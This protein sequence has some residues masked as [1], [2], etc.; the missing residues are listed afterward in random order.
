[1]DLSRKNCLLKKHP[2]LI[3][4]KNWDI[5][6]CSLPSLCSIIVIKGIHQYLGGLHFHKFCGGR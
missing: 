4:I 1:M 6:R 3:I 2:D 5:K